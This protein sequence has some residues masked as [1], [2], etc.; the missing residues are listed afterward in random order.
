ME[1]HRLGT[2]TPW[3]PVL[4]KVLSSTNSGIFCTSISKSIS[5]LLVRS[6]LSD[7]DHT[8]YCVV[9]RPYNQVFPFLG[10]PT[11]SPQRAVG[12]WKRF[13][14]PCGQQPNFSLWRILRNRSI[15]RSMRSSVET[16]CI[17]SIQPK[18]SR[19]HSLRER[20]RERSS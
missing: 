14:A 3:I 5:N 18:S 12:P 10:Q 16:A 20:K 6:S 7:L 4:L 9:T 8:Y 2:D 13:L 17:N 15:G 11:C 1:D 19:I